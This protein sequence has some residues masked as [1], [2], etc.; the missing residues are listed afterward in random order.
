MKLADS[1]VTACMKNDGSN[2]SA[3]VLRS[4]G[5]RA[6]TVGAVIKRGSKPVTVTI[7][8]PNERTAS[9]ATLPAISFGCQG[10]H[11]GVK[12]FSDD[13]RELKY[14]KILTGF[15]FFISFSLGTFSK[16]QNECMTNTL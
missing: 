7:H 16:G 6:K 1:D 10:P 12:H 4:C 15:C 13:D 2:L 14:L 3:R 8:M 9:I 11:G 5:S